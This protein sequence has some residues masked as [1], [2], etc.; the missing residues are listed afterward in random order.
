MT[1]SNVSHTNVHY[2]LF[3][4]TTLQSI[5]MHVFPPGLIQLVDDIQAMLEQAKKVIA[6]TEMTNPVKVT[7]TIKQLAKEAA[8]GMWYTCV[9]V[10]P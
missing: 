9:C 3:K 10:C 2:S 5:L 4:L 8:V 6:N 7:Y 1:W